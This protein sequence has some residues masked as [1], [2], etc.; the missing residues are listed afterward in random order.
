MMNMFKL[1][2]RLQ[3]FSKEQLAQEMQRPSGNA[4][5]YLVLAE[6]QRRKRMES[7][8]AME[9]GQQNE[10]TVA[11]DA[12][13]AAGVPQ[14]GLGG[15]MQ[16]MAPKTDVT[17]NTGQTPVQ[18]MYGGGVIKAQEGA[19]LGTDRLTSSL[20]TDPATRAMANRMGISV[21]EYI[22]NM[23]PQTRAAELQR[24]NRSKTQGAPSL[25][26]VFD[27]N[28]PAYDQIDVRDL[29]E[30]PAQSFQNLSD[31][32]LM[33]YGGVNPSYGTDVRDRAVGMGIS[34]RMPDAPSLDSVP[35]IAELSPFL[36]GG[37]QLPPE[38]SPQEDYTS[39]PNSRPLG[40]RPMA[41]LEITDDFFGAP[42]FDSMDS[43]SS[44]AELSP[45]LGDRQSPTSL[46][47]RP[48]PEK[49]PDLGDEPDRGGYVPPTMGATELNTPA[50]RTALGADEPS[51]WTIDPANTDGSLWGD[52]LPDIGNTATLLSPFASEEEKM[53]AAGSL[54][55]M[56]TG[57]PL[58][59]PDAGI[60]SL[61][62]PSPANNDPV[63]T[64]KTDDRSGGGGSSLG[65]SGKAVMSDLEKAFE[66]DKWLSLAKFGLG[67]MSS[68]QPT[69]GGAI[70]E[71]GLGA[72]ADFQQARKS[73]EE[74]T[75]ARQLMNAKLAAASR[76]GGGG[77]GKPVSSG[78]ITILGDQL[79][80][81]ESE[82]ANLAPARETWWG[83]GDTIDDDAGRRSEL[84][85]Q[86]DI[87]RA[88]LNYAL[89]SN[90]VPIPSTQSLGAVR[91]NIS[92]PSK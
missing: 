64:T 1:Q 47:L 28:T 89:S 23:D 38:L 81:L 19:Y 5:Q 7:A 34:D 33:E 74:N 41:E 66:Q 63:K 78:I 2:E 80:A 6:M 31:Y 53:A 91:A 79:A 25:S 75:M 54:G 15:M 10:T 37:S 18:Q 69:F 46:D 67:L 27:P 58:E 36:G 51:P 87:A 26:G 50:M 61:L 82:Y 21:R 77:G 72:I 9:Q 14:Q 90:G 52:I 13:A 76:S 11:Q 22:T 60:E 43:A 88:Q 16:A 73:Y 57:T 35:D 92:D 17:M 62:P 30:S 20:E 32:D 42:G 59:I 56:D 70:G 40:R 68:K 71:S 49:N 8:A 48:W 84:K 45:F 4:P 29:G 86:I 65:G 24:I 3:D 85:D 44:L 83:L 55:A 12:V 39:N